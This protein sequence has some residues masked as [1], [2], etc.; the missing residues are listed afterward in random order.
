MS[1]RRTGKWAGKGPRPGD[2]PGNM[3]IWLEA[4][5]LIAALVGAIA[6]LCKG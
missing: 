3:P 4:I 2:R 5:R 1:R 6:A